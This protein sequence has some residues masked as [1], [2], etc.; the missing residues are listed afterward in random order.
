MIER[1][2]MSLLFITHNLGVVAHARSGR[3]VYAS[4][5][6]SS[7]TGGYMAAAPHTVS[8]FIPWLTPVPD[9]DR[10]FGAKHDGAP[11]GCK[12]HPRCAH[13]GRLPP[14]DP[15]QEIAAICGFSSARS[16]MATMG[17]ADDTLPPAVRQTFTLR[18]HLFQARGREDQR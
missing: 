11:S 10:G 13:A 17:T 5:T 12:F 6:G 14:R 15:A 9:A 4:H 8:V 18:R 1:L 3:R 16:G 7:A 2:G